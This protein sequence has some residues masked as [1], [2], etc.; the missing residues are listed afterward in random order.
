[1][2]RLG[3][4]PDCGDYACPNCIR[5]EVEKVR[6]L[7]ELRQEE[8]PENQVALVSCLN[9]NQLG[10]PRRCVKLFPDEGAA[11]SWTFRLLVERKE[12]TEFRDGMS[13]FY[14]FGRPE[15]SNEVAGSTPKEVVTAWAEDLS[16]RE[17]FQVVPVLGAE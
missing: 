6:K 2:A 14:H 16:G 15:V 12:V 17:W 7:A 5:A 3:N 13:F 4:C 1:M 10:L 8:K 9:S 11:Y